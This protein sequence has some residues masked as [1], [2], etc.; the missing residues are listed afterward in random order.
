V[1]ETFTSAATLAELNNTAGRDVQ[2]HGWALDPDK[3]LPPNM[4]RWRKKL[5]DGAPA[6]LELVE[7]A[8]NSGAPQYM[9][10]AQVDLPC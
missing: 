1:G 10:A 9:L 7:Y 6:T 2:A 5:V 4:R 3:T 8:G